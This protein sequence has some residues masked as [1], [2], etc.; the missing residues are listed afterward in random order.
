MCSAFLLKTRQTCRVLVDRPHLCL[1]ADWLDGSVTA[2]RP[3]LAERGRAPM[4]LA[5][6]ADIVP[7]E[8]SF[9]AKFRGLQVSDGLIFFLGDIDGRAIP[10]AHQ[11]GQWHGIAAVRVPAV[12]GL[13]WQEGG[14]HHPAVIA[15]VAQI[16]R[17]TR[18]MA[19]LRR[20]R[21]AV[22]PWMAW[23]G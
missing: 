23:F 5:G 21:T 22:W 8:E 12:T 20:H 3:E 16:A 13:F 14:R 7:E 4:S 1:E 9:E 2:H 11:P 6:V 18:H 15:L 17:A 19:P 10:R